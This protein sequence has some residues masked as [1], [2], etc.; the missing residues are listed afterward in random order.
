MTWQDFTMIIVGMFIVGG[1]FYRIIERTLDF[2]FEHI[3]I[4]LRKHKS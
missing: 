4:K 1:L 2:I 3:E